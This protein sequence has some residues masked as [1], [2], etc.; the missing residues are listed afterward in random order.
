MG[1]TKLLGLSPPDAMG[2]RAGLGSCSRNCGL[3]EASDEE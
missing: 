1:S 3:V 2:D